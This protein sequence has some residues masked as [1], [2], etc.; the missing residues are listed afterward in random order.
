LQAIDQMFREAEERANHVAA[1]CARVLDR[2]TVQRLLLQIKLNML[3][4]GDVPLA[5]IDSYFENSPQDAFDKFGEVLEK[6]RS[7]L[8]AKGVVLPPTELT[9]DDLCS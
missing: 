9:R 7:S 5:T 4:N 6:M 2:Q 8:A 1:V 3:R